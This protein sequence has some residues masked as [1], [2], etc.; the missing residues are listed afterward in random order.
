MVVSK[1]YNSNIYKHS[2]TYSTVSDR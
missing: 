1:F 2:L